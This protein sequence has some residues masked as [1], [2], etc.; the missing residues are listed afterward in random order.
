MDMIKLENGKLRAG[1]YGYYWVLLSAEY[2]GEEDEWTVALFDHSWGIEGLWT[3]GGG[4]ARYDEAIIEVGAKI[5]RLGLLRRAWRA[6]RRILLRP[7][8]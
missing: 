7:T 8:S 5:E 3:V 6:V 2:E 4:N 1:G